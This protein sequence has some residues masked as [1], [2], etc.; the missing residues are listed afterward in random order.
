M[1]YSNKDFVPIGQLLREITKRALD[2]DYRYNTKG[3][4]RLL[5]QNCLQELSYDAHFMKEWF[6]VEIPENLS[7]E[8]PEGAFNVRQMYIFN[9]DFCNIQTAQNVYHAR[10][11]F[12]AGKGLVKNN[13][14]NNQSD[15]FFRDQASN[16]PRV[17]ASIQ[18]SQANGGG[19]AGNTVFFF[20][21]Q[22]GRVMLSKSTSRFE[23][24]FFRSDLIPDIDKG[25]IVPKFLQRA[26]TLYCAREGLQP[27]LAEGSQFVNLYNELNK[28]LYG[29]DHE[30][31]GA[32]YKAEHRV[33]Q[34]DYKERE[35]LAEY[36]QRLNY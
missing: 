10:Q 30:S 17:F 3:Y 6:T 32:W 1:N 12:T 8:L 19:R 25:G 36:H 4:Y 18:G 28:D 22:D 27:R 9:G 21:I 2:S 24:V 11:Y 31:D 34:M 20:N 35:D 23:K 7:F 14:Q 13:K 16:N 29:R 15:P 26:V 33:Q 5:I